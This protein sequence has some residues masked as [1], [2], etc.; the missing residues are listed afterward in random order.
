MIIKTNP[1]EYQ[2]WLGDTSGLRPGQLDGVW[3]PETIEEV[4]RFLSECHQSRSPVTISGNG[5]GTTGGRVPFKGRLLATDR[6]NQI[7]PIKVTSSDEAFIR[8]EAGIPLR[9]VQDTVLAAG[10]LYPPD[11]TERNAF[12][13]GTISTNASGARSFRFGS[14]RRWV[15]SIELILPDGFPLT[16]RRGEHLA[17]NGVFSFSSGGRSF[18]FSIPHYSMP[19]IKH[20][21]G[22]YVQQDMDL[23]DLFIGS[24]GTLG[25]ITAATL[26]LIRK[27]EK[28]FSAILFF[29]EENHLLSFVDE[30][31]H[32]SFASDWEAGK[33]AATSLEF[34]DHQ[35]LRFLRDK[36]PQTP[37]NAAGAVYFEQE[38]NQGNEDELLAWWFDLA[39]QHQAMLDLSWFAQTPKEDDFFKEYRHALPALINEFLNR[40]RVKKISSDIAVPE[41]SF[42][43]MMKTYHHHLDNSPFRW[44]IF[45]H[46]GDCHLHMNILPHSAEEHDRGKVIY[47]EF[48][49]AA[50]AMGG[51]ISAEHGVG[52]LKVDYLLDMYGEDGLR[53]MAAVKRFFDPHLI[54]G[55]GTL[56]PERLLIS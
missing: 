28:F 18:Q 33:P 1:D 43:N 10:W 4:S 21:A 16:I 44:V 40:N 39:S 27:P 48:I 9:T 52:K 35:S 41:E 51:T 38:C 19:D 14:T 24:E 46:I 17:K 36:Y 13:G 7:G 49:N 11:P 8:V 31:R 45:G 26:R 56:I 34:F 37:A 53:Q 42:R 30:A 20:A 15:E 6:L 22:Y 54:L 25:I 5:T 32:L 23:I 2:S 3:F 55:Q 47:R 50:L 29:D 12:I